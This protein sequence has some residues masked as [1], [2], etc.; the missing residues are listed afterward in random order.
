MLDEDEGKDLLLKVGAAMARFSLLRRME[1]LAAE[2]KD[3]KVGEESVK[4]ERS[5]VEKRRKKT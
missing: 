2:T 4:I 3:A 5:R 1:A